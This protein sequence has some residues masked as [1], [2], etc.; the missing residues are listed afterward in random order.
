[1][2]Y[3]T[4]NTIES[5]LNSKRL[6]LNATIDLLEEDK[7]GTVNISPEV[8]LDDLAKWLESGLVYETVR[9]N[10]VTFRME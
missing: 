10:S 7:S 1:M 6:I 4:F 5:G 8:S 9:I 3:V 2:S